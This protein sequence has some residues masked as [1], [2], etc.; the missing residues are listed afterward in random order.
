M[1]TGV[2]AD[3]QV[4]IVEL[5]TGKVVRDLPSCSSP[6]AVAPDARYV[7][8]DAVIAEVVNAC[9]EAPSPVSGIYDVAKQK[10]VVDYERRHV[11]YGAVS[12]DSTFDGTRYAAAMID[13][14]GTTR[15]EMW[16]LDPARLLG[17]VT[18]ETVGDLY[19]LL[20]EFSSDGRYLAI[21]TG[22]SKVLV[23]DIE[24]LSDGADVEDAVVFDKEV[25]TGNAPLAHVTEDRR[26]IT[27]GFDG[28]YRFWDLD[29]GSLLF[30]MEVD[31]VRF[32]P[33][34][35]LSPDETFFYYEDG[36]GVVRRMPTDLDE[37]IE[38]SVGS[39]TRTLSDDECRRYLHTDGCE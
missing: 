16:A 14:E 27:A 25:H 21:G 22:G 15:V 1:I 24:H 35:D 10:L 4:K 5:G 34:H 36:N 9:G 6:S 13:T 31:D 7:V 2:E 26:V 20:L 19:I 33:A 11:R 12:D 30:E 3:G 37:M 23:V 28:F 32:A 38:L 8:L 29:S 17:T 18:Q 39:V